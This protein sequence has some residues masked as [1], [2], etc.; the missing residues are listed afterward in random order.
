MLPFL[1]NKQEG[2]ASSPVETIE[3]LPDEGA[4]WDMLDAVAADLMMAFEKKDIKL[5]KN[6]LESLC[7]HIMALDIEQDKM[8]G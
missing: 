3:R 8:E 2:A 1:R 5:L 7:E 6:A 4:E